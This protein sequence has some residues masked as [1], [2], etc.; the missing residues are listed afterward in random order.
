MTQK[1]S[2]DRHMRLPGTIN[3]RDLGGYK[4]IERGRVKM[5]HLFRSGHLTNATPEAGVAIADLGIGLVCDFR[6]EK[7]RDEHPNRYADGHAPTT[8]H[9]PIWPAGTPGVDNTVARLLRG[10]ASPAQALA[11]QCNG[12]R[13]FVR[14]QSDRFAG[15]FAALAD[16][17]P[18]A[19]LMHCSA[20]K[21]RT[22]IAAALLL[23]ALG[24][25][26]RDVM[27]DYLLSREGHGARDQTQYYVDLYWEA[28]LS[29]HNSTPACTKDDMHAL[30]SSQPEKISAAFEEMEQVAG[31]VDAYIRDTL[32]VTDDM[33]GALQHHYVEP[34]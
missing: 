33:R 34:A 5:G 27:E 12:Y 15:L 23:T 32:G 26:R 20:G 14:D 28:H 29:S 25:S 13:E 2:I 18:G 3:M 17:A 6:I 10:D 21:D 11:D 8:A 16:H 22:G 4:T 30:F 31:S 1:A 24:V 7:E 9:L 19:M